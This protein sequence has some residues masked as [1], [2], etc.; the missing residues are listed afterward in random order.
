M[1]LIWPYGPN[2]MPNQVVLDSPVPGEAGSV[3]EGD[4]SGDSHR[5]I[6]LA[7]LDGSGYS[8]LHSGGPTRA[9]RGKVT[10]SDR[11][12]RKRDPGT[13][14]DL[15]SLDPGTSAPIF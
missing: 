9:L 4:G 5:R 3:D 6:R 13:C 12:E 1:P 11:I 15:A 10:E 7:S 8:E 14:P 2:K